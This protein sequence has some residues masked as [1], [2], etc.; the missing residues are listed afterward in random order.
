MGDDNNIFDDKPLSDLGSDRPGG[1]RSL[2]T[3]GRS[4]L[5]PTDG[6]RSSSGTAESRFA[7]SQL[8]YQSADATEPSVSRQA[9][10]SPSLTR[11]VPA[12]IDGF[13]ASRYQNG[14]QPAPARLGFKSHNP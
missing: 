13:A 12:N 2:T 11:Q 1:D 5:N 9:P 6:S 3:N 4:S 14:G 10:D 8:S 7:S